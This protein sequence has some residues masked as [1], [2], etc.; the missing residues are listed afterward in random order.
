MV[1]IRGEKSKKA[2]SVIIIAL[3]PKKKFFND[4]LKLL[5][6]PYSTKA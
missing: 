6:D 2:I 5:D 3:R 1:L 4:L